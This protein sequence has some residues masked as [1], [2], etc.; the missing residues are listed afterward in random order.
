DFS[1]S[2]Y[3]FE[4]LP[5]LKGSKD[6]FEIYAL[7]LNLDT[8]TS[9][10][11]Y[12]LHVQGRARDSKLRPFFLS[13]VW[14]QEA[15]A[16]AKTGY[17]DLHVGKFYRK[18]GILWDDSFFGNV[19]YFNGLKLNP[20]Y[21]AEFVGSRPMG[22]ALTVDYSGQYLNNN[23]HVAGSLDGRDVESD[24]D[25]RMHATVTGRIAPSW[26]LSDDTSLTAG[27][28]GLSGRI[29][30]TN[31]QSFRI[32]QIAG[33]LTLK[34]RRSISYVELLRQDGER[35]DSLHS[36]G[37]LGYDDADY[38]LAGTRWQLTPRANARLNASRVRYRGHREVETEVVPGLVFSL[39][40]HL[41]L[42]GE[43]DWWKT[44]PANGPATFIDKSW[45][46]VVDY[47]FQ[48]N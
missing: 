24:P 42:I 28:S 12:G 7:V 17:G 39:D 30:R 16:Y 27:F 26:K 6:K 37:R 48:E 33:D 21:G 29:E 22:G 46:F 4:Y 40:K 47:Q 43:Y 35:F 9:D 5:T 45:N 32:S 25:A 44:N 41:S 23:D 8:R 1:G 10:E 38:L 34:W 3:L 19:Q 15:Y 18:V 2:I 31:A 11:K 13:N 14:F 20:D 36:N